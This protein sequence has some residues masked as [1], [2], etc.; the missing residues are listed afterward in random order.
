ME[1]GADIVIELPTIYSISSAENF[2]E[3]AIKI[4]DSLKIVDTLSF[5]TETQDFAALNNIANVV[6]YE[7]KEYVSLLNH[8]LGKGVSFPKA[9]ENAVLMYLND[10]KRYANILSGANNIL[11]IEYIKALRRFKSYLKPFSVQ[12]IKVY[13]ND[14]HIVDDFASATA[15]RKMVKREQYEDIRKVVPKNS[16]ALL[17]EEIKRGNIVMGLESFEKEILYTL[18]KMTV[19]EIQNL[20]DVTEGLENNIKNAANSCNNLQDLMNIIKSKRY[21]QTRIQRILLYSL[22]GI[23]K[24]DMEIA[25][26]ITPYT[27]VLGFNEKGKEMLS[28]I[29]H[30]NPKINIVTSV[31]KFMDNSSN[32]NLK[33]MLEKDI[34]ASNVYTLGY[35]YDSWANLDYTNKLIVL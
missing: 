2:A 22:L 7:P 15:I 14:E 13:Y 34:F 11:A 16:Y 4:L 18:R 20:P 24:K 28:D 3:G 6:Y 12:R 30:I 27:R 33:E 25:R 23:T 35:A 31:K 17:Q 19:K 10:I 21:T 5:G 26:K 9:R 32:K 8:E 29:C 1:N